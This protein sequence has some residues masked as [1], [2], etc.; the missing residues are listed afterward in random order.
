[1]RRAETATEEMD[2]PDCDPVLLW[3]TYQQFPLVNALVSGWRGVYRDLIRPALPTTNATILDIGCG[4]GDITRALARRARADGFDITVT[5]IDPDPRAYRFAS[6]TATGRPGAEVVFEQASSS[7]LV[8]AGRS[9]DVV[10]SNHVLHHLSPTGLDVLLADTE[11]LTRAVAVHADLRRSRLAGLLFGAATLP[12]AGT[13]FIRRDGLTSIR[14][15]YLP[16]E[17][18]AVVPGG[19]RVQPRRPFRNLL[20]HRPD[21]LP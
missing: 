12:L 10:V 3:R 18:R 4:G 2:R 16:A 1:M 14:R 9:F 19:W 11:Q 20:I 15:S 17:L 6:R 13:S 8:A 7:D 21:P 5:G